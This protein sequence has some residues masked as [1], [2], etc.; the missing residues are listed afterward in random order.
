MARM[1]DEEVTRRIEI[2]DH[3]LISSKLNAHRK[4][5]KQWLRRQPPQV[6]Q[7]LSVD[8]ILNFVRLAAQDRC[9]VDVQKVLTACLDYTATHN[10]ADPEAWPCVTLPAEWPARHVERSSSAPL[11]NDK[12][13]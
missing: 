10:N 2:N 11:T 5:V 7:T 12:V 3:F 6:R 4:T 8:F 1:T 9:E 13:A